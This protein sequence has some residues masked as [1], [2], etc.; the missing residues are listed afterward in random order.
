MSTSSP[1]RSAEL[2]AR[3]HSAAIHLLRRVRREDRA[4][5][6][7]PSR[8]SALSVLVFGGARSLGDLAEA[9]QVTP[10]TMSRLVDRLE[11]DGFARRRAAPEDARSVIVEPTRRGE[12]LL[13]RAQNR[14]IRHLSE[15]LSERNSQELETL[16][17]ATEI[18]EATLRQAED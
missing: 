13:R 16:R 10:A 8:L 11:A 17:R 3:L 4:A 1:P 14:R 6:L 18:I 9:E 15:L 12:R 2:A 7:S 5:G